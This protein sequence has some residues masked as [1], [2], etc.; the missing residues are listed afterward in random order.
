MIRPDRGVALWLLT[1]AAMVFLIV[2]IGGITRLTESGLSITEWK[3]VSGIVPPLS[4]AQWTDEFVRYQQTTEYQ[5]L[6][7][8]M[9]LGEFKVIFF[10]EYLHRL[11]GRLIGVAF[12]IPFFYLLLKGRIE[13]RLRIRLWTIL[14]LI[15]AQGALGWYMVQSGLSERTDVSQYRLTA[16][17]SLALLIYGM[18]LWLGISLLLRSGHGGVAPFLISPVRANARRRVLSVLVMVCVTIVSGAFVAGLN[19]GKIFNTFP[20]MGDAV[21]PPGYMQLSPWILNFFENPATAQFNHRLLAMATFGAVVYLWAWARRIDLPPVARG[22]VHWLAAIALLQLSL[23]IVTLLAQSP[24]HLAA[25]HQ[26]GAVALLT[27]G[28]VTLRG[29]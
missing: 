25:A 19:A 13:P 18:L 23:G 11:W 4:Q 3:P 2:V 12:A 28:L 20:L 29:L 6:N 26:A 10:W 16:H 15:G 1:C 14:A 27:V 9:S 22:G 7:R 21:I 24:V 5:E 17:L 8:G